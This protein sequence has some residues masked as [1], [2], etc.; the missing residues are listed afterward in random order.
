MWGSE[1]V[2][3]RDPVC[4]FCGLAFGQWRWGGPEGQRVAILPMGLPD[5]RRT[6][7]EETEAWEWVLWRDSGREQEKSRVPFY[8]H[9]YP[10][11]SWEL[12]R[13]GLAELAGVAWNVP[14]FLETPVSSALLGDSSS[15]SYFFALNPSLPPLL[16]TFD[17]SLMIISKKFIALLTF[18]SVILLKI[19][20]KEEYIQHTYPTFPTFCLELEFLFFFFFKDISQ[21]THL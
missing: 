3:C 4:W 21:G 12:S 10:P 8:C 6:L 14:P 17:Y 7:I 13:W 20:V 11:C 18:P 15:S 2:M 16:V 1:K 5:L 19:Q 9:H